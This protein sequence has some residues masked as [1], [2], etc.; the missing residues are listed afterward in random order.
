MLRTSHAARSERRGKAK[1]KGP[2]PPMQHSSESPRQETEEALKLQSRCGQLQKRWRCGVIMDCGTCDSAPTL[3]VHAPEVV[4]VFDHDGQ[5]DVHV[6]DAFGDD[7]SQRCW[8]VF[9]AAAVPATCTTRNR[10][11]RPCQVHINGFGNVLSPPAICR[12]G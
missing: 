9:L 12:T 1:G 7:R 3:Q 10:Y 2:D 8:L 4:D 6:E 5:G 11:H